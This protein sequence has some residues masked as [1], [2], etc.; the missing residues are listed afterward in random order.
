[1]RG[2][3]YIRKDS[4][5]KE[6]GVIAEEIN[7]ILPDVVL[8]NEEGQ[9]DSVSYGRLSAVF[10]EAIKELKQEINEQSLIISELK[11]KLGI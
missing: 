10:I 3:T 11:S 4:E 9:V 8:K 6:I 1:M 2:V 5:V 7:E